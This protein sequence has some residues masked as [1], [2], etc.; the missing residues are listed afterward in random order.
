MR[1]YAMTIAVA[2]VPVLW[3]TL[4]AGASPMD[5]DV[6]PYDVAVVWTASGAARLGNDAEHAM[7]MDAPSAS[8]VATSEGG[9]LDDGSRLE[10]FSKR[11]C[12]RE[13]ARRERRVL[14][15]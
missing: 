13:A 8:P 12:A 14:R 3:V 10:T 1:R 11:E 15:S 7:L 9:G 5:G 6:R 4:G 2:A